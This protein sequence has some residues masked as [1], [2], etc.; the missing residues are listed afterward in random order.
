MNKVIERI[1]DFKA[2]SWYVLSVME[3]VQE[4]WKV[5]ATRE[6]LERLNVPE[7]EQIVR[8]YRCDGGGFGHWQPDHGICYRCK[9][10]GFINIHVP[11]WLAALRHCRENYR[12]AR[13]KWLKT[14]DENDFNRMEIILEN[15]KN[16]RSALELADCPKEWI[17]QGYWPK[18]IK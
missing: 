2:S 15:G 5:L 3:S 18:E 9:G 6:Q 16:L 13:N 12:E 1:L 7:K 11:R 14:R 4:R 17:E 8:C 10:K